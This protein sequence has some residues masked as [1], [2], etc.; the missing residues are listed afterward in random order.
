[1][2][3]L[4]LGKAVIGVARLRAHKEHLNDHQLEILQQ[5]SDQGHILWCEDFNE[6]PHFIN[7][8]KTFQPRPYPFDNQALI[9]AIAA[10]LTAL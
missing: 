6:L 7:Q 2:D 9:N 5:F 10:D 8:A 3:G 4:R 1:L